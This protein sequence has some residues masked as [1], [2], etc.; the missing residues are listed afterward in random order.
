MGSGQRSRVAK[1]GRCNAKLVY[2]QDNTGQGIPK[3]CVNNGVVLHNCVHIYLPFPPQCSN[4]LRPHQCNVT[5]CVHRHTILILVLKEVWPDDAFSS[6]GILHSH[7][8]LAKRAM[9]M[10][11]GLSLGPEAHICLLMCPLK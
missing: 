1:E 3:K 10:F 7:F 2:H 6:D 11:M 9:V 5:V 4:E 8:L